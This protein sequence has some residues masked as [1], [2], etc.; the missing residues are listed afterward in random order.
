MT[1]TILP[2]LQEQEEEWRQYHR[3][4]LNS[5]LQRFKCK[6][7]GKKKLSPVYIWYKKIIGIIIVKM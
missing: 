2:P 3:R 5:R 4:S 7:C 1:T 6:I